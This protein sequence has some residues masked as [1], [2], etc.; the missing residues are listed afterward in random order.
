LDDIA[1]CGTEGYV[2]QKQASIPARSKSQPEISIKYLYTKRVLRPLNVI[3]RAM[4]FA[5]LLC[6][7]VRVIVLSLFLN[8]RP[9]IYT[10]NDSLIGD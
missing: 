2:P 9:A 5:E 4:D 7:D 3:G 10:I 6:H 1:R 8:L